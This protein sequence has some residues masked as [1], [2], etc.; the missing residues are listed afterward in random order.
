MS[1]VDSLIELRTKLF[2]ESSVRVLNGWRTSPSETPQRSRLLL[3]GS[4]M[5]LRLVDCSPYL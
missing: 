2:D 5:L 3:F 1:I 4:F